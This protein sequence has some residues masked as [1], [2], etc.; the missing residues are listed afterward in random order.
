M[1]GNNTNN[2]S[3]RG[4][5][6]ARLYPWSW[7]SENLDGCVLSPPQISG[8]RTSSQNYWEWAS[9]VEDV[10]WWKWLQDKNGLNE[11]VHGGKGCV[12]T[13]NASKSIYSHSNTKVCETEK[14]VWNL[15]IHV[16]TLRLILRRQMVWEL[17]TLLTDGEMTS[18]KSHF[19]IYHLQ[20]EQTAGW[21][22][23]EVL[24]SCPK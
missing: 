13:K 23:E 11:A 4:G 18:E 6:P 14:T 1:G 3:W 5:S 19:C 15:S 20:P 12:R 22:G 17:F 7:V 2:S 10:S 16:T 8:G 21:K 9:A 24:H